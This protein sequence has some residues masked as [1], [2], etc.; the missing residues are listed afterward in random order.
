MFNHYGVVWLERGAATLSFI[1]LYREFAQPTGVSLQRENKTL[2]PKFV[3]FAG[4]KIEGGNPLSLFFYLKQTIICWTEKDNSRPPQYTSYSCLMHPNMECHSQSQNS[5][6]TFDSWSYK[7]KELSSLAAAC[8]RLLSPTSKPF[9]CHFF[10]PTT[11][12]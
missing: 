9:H 11:C 7:K 1:T 5:R 3:V 4:L 12:A 2:L 6:A 10:F 8:L